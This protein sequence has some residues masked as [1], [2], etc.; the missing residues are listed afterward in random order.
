MWYF[1]D[2]KHRCVSK[3]K[4]LVSAKLKR[5]E[6]IKAGVSPADIRVSDAKGR[7]Y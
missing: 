5:F 2:V 3:H 6:L 7:D 1:V 4:V